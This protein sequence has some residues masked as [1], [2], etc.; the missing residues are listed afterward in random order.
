MLQIAESAQSI[1][2]REGKTKQEQ[3]SSCR[4]GLA[5]ARMENAPD[6][7]T[8][9]GKPVRPPECPETVM[10]DSGKVTPESFPPTEQFQGKGGIF[11]HTQ[12]LAKP[13]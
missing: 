7:G 13:G 11:P 3:R 12:G 4:P 5:W 10:A 2:A 8:L 6:L 9:T 1:L